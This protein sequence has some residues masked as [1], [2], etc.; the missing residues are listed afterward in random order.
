MMLAMNYVASPNNAY[1]AARYVAARSD[2]PVHPRLHSWGATAM[3]VV[4]GAHMLTTFLSGSYKFRA[5]RPG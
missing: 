1:D 4:V 3:V 2:G 5:S